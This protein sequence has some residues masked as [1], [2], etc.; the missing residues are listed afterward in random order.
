MKLNNFLFKNI[1]NSAMVVFRIVFGLLIFLESVGSCFTGWIKRTMIEPQFTFNFIG[2]DFLQPL[3]GYGM[4]VYYCIMGVFGL[5]VMLGYRYRLATIAFTIMWAGVYFMQKAS[6]NNHYYLLMLLSAIMCFLPANNY[7][8]LDA[9]QGRVK[10]SIS[11]PNWAKWTLIGQMWIVYTYGALQ[12]LYP[13]WLDGTFTGLLLNSKATQYPFMAGLL[14]DQS[15]HLFI[16]YSGIFYDLLIIPLLLWRRTRIYA[17]GASFIFHLFN[18]FVFHVGI[19]PY[20]SLAFSLFFFD[21]K[22]V[23]NI[24]LKKK[25]LYTENLVTIPS[26]GAFI[27][28][29]FVTYLTIQF[30]LPIRNLVIQDSVFW[31]EEGHRMSWR[32][33]LRSKSGYINF[34]V[35]NHNTGKTTRINLED[36][37]SKKQRRM[38]ATKPD[39]IW[40]FVQRIKNEYEGQDI[41][42]YANGK[43]SLNGRKYQRLVDP[44]V[45]LAKVSWNYFGHQDWLVPF[46]GWQKEEIKPK[47]SSLKKK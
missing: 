14:R 42:I 30:L 11:I 33:M 45:D 25:E 37:L 40:Q 31:T 19:F 20:L 29:I 10:K 9:K 15:F 22:T 7:A 13:D 35:V 26:N 4:Y 1:D 6:Y 17:F 41:S 2:L 32:M 43:V 3:D 38:I 46:E 18:S 5:F 44:K 36:Y 21:A 24:F 39:V 34:R 16:A 8:S 23:R 28:T 47:V 27:K 12:K